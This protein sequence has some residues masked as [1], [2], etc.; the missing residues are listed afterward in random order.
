MRASSSKI[1]GRF[2]NRHSRPSHLPHLRKGYAMLPR[3]AGLYNN[4]I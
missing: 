3:A 1:G 4:F 2:R